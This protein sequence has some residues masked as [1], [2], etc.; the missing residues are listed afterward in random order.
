MEKE[1]LKSNSN[2]LPDYLLTS[3]STFFSITCESNI[4][5]QDHEDRAEPGQRLY[6]LL[7]NAIQCNLAQTRVHAQC[8][9]NWQFEFLC[10]RDQLVFNYFSWH[11][12]IFVTSHKNVY[13]S[14]NDNGCGLWVTIPLTSLPQMQV[15]C[16]LF[17]KAEMFNYVRTTVV[18]NNQIQQ[19]KYYSSNVWQEKR[20]PYPEIEIN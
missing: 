12:F 8:L 19:N 9:P 18:W 14:T 11:T 5:A 15:G 16:S 13:V 10:A 7:L 6:R 4:L 20:C 2:K 17:T 3:K 1:P